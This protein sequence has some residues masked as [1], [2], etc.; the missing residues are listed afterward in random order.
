MRVT[1]RADD[2]S[3]VKWVRLRYRHVTQFED[4]QTAEMT[5]DSSSGLY[6][7]VIPGDFIVSRWDL[8]YFVEVMDSRGNGAF[9]RISTGRFPI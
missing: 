8:M 6:S 7:A 4:Y 5:K 1:L 9:I 3:G 2:P